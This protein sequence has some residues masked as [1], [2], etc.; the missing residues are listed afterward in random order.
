MGLYPA[1]GLICDWGPSTVCTRYLLGVL[2]P[3][4]LFLWIPRP[5]TR[6]V[7]GQGGGWEGAMG[8]GFLRVPRLHGWLAPTQ[9][10]RSMFADV[11]CVYLLS[12]ICDDFSQLGA[13]MC[14]VLLVAQL[15]KATDP[16]KSQNSTPVHEV[17]S[18]PQ[19]HF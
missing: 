8:Y 9:V 14:M 4:V 15:G 19:T 18:R 12:S 13:P 5:K 3:L 2:R 6:D 10:N 16:P 7:G 11:Y 17:L 1:R